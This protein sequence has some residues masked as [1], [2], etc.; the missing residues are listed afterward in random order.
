MNE[1]F[2]PAYS[3]AYDLLYQDKDYGAECD[4]LERIFKTYGDGSIQDVLDIGCGTG[5]HALPLAERGYQVTGV[6]RSE[7][8]LAKAERKRAQSNKRDNVVFQRGDLRTLRLGRQF[9]AALTMFAVLGY[10]NHNADVLS[11]LRAARS[12]LRPGGILVFDVWYGPAVLQ[13]RP[14][15]RVKLVPT[16]GGRILRAS[17]GELDT[18]RHVCVVHYRLWR[19]ENGRVAAESEERHS[20]RYFFPLELD[21]FLQSSGF[22]LLRLG[23]FPA[24][25]RDPDETTW[26]VI[27]IASA[28]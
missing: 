20:M 6:D 18:L 24:F 28:A 12:H 4:L 2:G 15:E 10:Q 22:R 3:H 21:L 27:G 13:Q 9:D 1:G 14:S 8:M 16:P 7:E 5:N 26:N 19:L 11:A 17:S 23:A 25:E